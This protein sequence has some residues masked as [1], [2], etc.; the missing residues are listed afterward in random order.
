MLLAAG[1]VRNRLEPR[2]RFS[3]ERS[4]Q[5]K[6][7]L[8]TMSSQPRIPPAYSY[9]PIS[10][11]D[12]HVAG[13]SCEFDIRLSSSKVR[14]WLVWWS[15]VATA[16]A[17]VSL[18][19]LGLSALTAFRASSKMSAS[20][21]E[22]QLS[23]KAADM[24]TSSSISYMRPHLGPKRPCGHSAEEAKAAGCVFDIMNVAWMPWDCYDQKLS[25]QFQKEVPFDFFYADADGMPT[26]RRIPDEK[27]LSEMDEPCWATREYHVLHCTFAWKMMHRAIERGWRIESTTTEFS[28]TEHCAHILTN[29][30]VPLE[31]VVTEVNIGYPSC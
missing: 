11:E 13:Q 12:G 10:K 22:Q 14:R 24:A 3:N 1:M 20:L 28:H 15:V 7:Q 18:P 27:T 8:A 5:I 2:V 25:Y 6:P 21:E 29:R 17:L 16:F 23:I 30:T 26:S 31:A 9:E 19:L 4:S